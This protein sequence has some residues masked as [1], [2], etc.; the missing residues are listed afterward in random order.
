MQLNFTTLFNINY[1]AKG[2]ALYNSLLSNC[3]DF[4]LYIFAADEI[5]YK[6]LVEKNLSK[7]SIISLHEIE[8][9]ALLG[10]KKNRSISEYCWTCKPF[11]VRYCFETFG[12]T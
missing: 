9:E 12:L 10:V 4:N 6:I 2:I 3:S 11:I 1:L 7:V 8:N 5:S